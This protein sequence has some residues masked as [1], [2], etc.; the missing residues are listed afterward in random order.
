MQYLVNEDEMK[1][2]KNG[3]GLGLDIE[4]SDL[5]RLCTRI[6][7]KMPVVFSWAPKMAPVP[8]G[9]VIMDT[10]KYCDE[11]PV[12]VICPYPHKSFSK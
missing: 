8:W 5:Q 2:L 4:K 10:V 1:A 12:K 6:A 9:C 11:C 3:S 7:T